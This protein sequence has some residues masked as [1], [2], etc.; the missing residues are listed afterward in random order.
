MEISQAI[1][2]FLEYCEHYLNDFLAFAIAD[3]ADN[4]KAGANPT[5]VIALA[6]LI[7]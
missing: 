7:S 1:R 6:T 5:T 2:R 3:N 4:N